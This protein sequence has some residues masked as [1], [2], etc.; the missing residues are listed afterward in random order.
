MFGNPTDREGVQETTSFQRFY[1]IAP[2]HF[3][4][5]FID[6]VSRS[7]LKLNDFV[8]KIDKKQRKYAHMTY[9]IRLTIGPYS[10]VATKKRTLRSL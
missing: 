3:E 9:K 6:S 7:V 1:C 2:E 8:K 5:M 4:V 10:N